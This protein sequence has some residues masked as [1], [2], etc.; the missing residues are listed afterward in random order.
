MSSQ[1]TTPARRLTAP[2]IAAK[3]GGTPIVSLTAYNAQTAAL[4]DRHCDFLLVATA[5]AW[6]CTAM[7][8]PCQ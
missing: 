6:W 2:D 5:W 8:A 3:K 4:A 1:P 7:T